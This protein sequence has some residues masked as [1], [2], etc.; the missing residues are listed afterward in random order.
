MHALDPSNSDKN[1]EFLRLLARHESRLSTCVHA[2]VPGWHDAE[3]ILQET[4]V[5]LWDQF[6]KFTLGTAFGAWSCT[7]AR[8]MVLDYRERASRQK[9]YFS[10]DVMELIADKLEDRSVEADTRLKALIKCV[11]KLDAASRD[12][13]RCFY[14]EHMKVKDIAAQAGRSLQ[15]TYSAI[16]RT[17]RSWK[18]RR[19]RY[20][21]TLTMRFVDLRICAYRLTPLDRRRIGVPRSSSIVTSG[22]ST[23]TQ[24]GRSCKS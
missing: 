10:G 1:H 21:R 18:T 8:Y 5:R 3:D 7:V 13:L 4:K 15:S 20:G 16:S 2:M 19:P 11:A 23:K 6:E 24:T 9:L 12:L 22:K 17:R 14:A